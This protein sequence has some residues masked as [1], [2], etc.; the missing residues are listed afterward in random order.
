MKL[1][2]MHGAWWTRM[3]KFDDLI[4]CIIPMLEDK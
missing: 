3:E 2:Y 1:V 4:A